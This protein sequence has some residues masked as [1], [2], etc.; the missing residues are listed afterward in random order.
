MDTVLPLTAGRKLRLF[1]ANDPFKQWWSLEELRFCAKCERLFIGRDIKVLED[2]NGNI[3]FQCPTRRCLGS[4]ADWEY[5]QLH[6]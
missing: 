6:L 2:E 3:T 1:Q 4:F 5:P